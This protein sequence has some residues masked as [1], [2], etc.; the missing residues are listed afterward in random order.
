MMKYGKRKKKLF[1]CGCATL[2]FLY[3]IIVTGCSSK[4]SIVGTWYSKE[5]DYRISF[6]EDGTC[7]SGDNGEI[8][9]YKQQEDGTLMLTWGLFGNQRIISRT[10]DKE[11]ALEED[12]YYYLSGNTLVFYGSEC[13]RK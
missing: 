3:G 5:S 4:N 1:L 13:E 2:V 7:T 9:N 11:Q 6:Y 8:I 12:E 10:D